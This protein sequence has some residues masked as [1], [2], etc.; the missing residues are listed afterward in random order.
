MPD[1]ERVE[2]EVRPW[3]AMRA[4][5]TVEQWANRL[6]DRAERLIDRAM[7]STSEP[8]KPHKTPGR[9]RWDRVQRAGL[10]AAMERGTMPTY[11][12]RREVRTGRRSAGRRTDWAAALVEFI[13]ALN[14]Y[15]Y[16]IAHGGFMDPDDGVTDFQPYKRAKLLEMKLRLVAAGMMPS[17]MVALSEQILSR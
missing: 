1:D 3:T 4:D 17:E 14:D 8:R 12:Q 13:D 11:N 6:D 2:V 10:E 5:E 16:R 15:A 7:R 9:V